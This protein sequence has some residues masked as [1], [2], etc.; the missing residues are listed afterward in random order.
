MTDYDACPKCDTEIGESPTTGTIPSARSEITGWHAV[1][2]VVCPHC[3]Y[4]LDALPVY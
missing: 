4:L 1:Q 2:V 3:N